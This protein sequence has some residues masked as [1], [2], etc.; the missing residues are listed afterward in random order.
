MPPAIDASHAPARKK[1]LI[2]ED[3][4]IVARD[5]KRRLEKQG[6]EVTGIADNAVD[7]LRSV[8]EN[9]PDIAL[10]DII[11]QGDRDGIATA[12]EMRTRHDMP[13]VFLTAHSDMAT[14]RRA[15]D[16][17]PY[18]YLVKPFEEREL[19]STIEVAVYRHQSE[20]Q[21]RL[22][23]RAISAT[24]VGMLITDACHP[25]HPIISCNA[26]FERI[27]GYTEAEIIGKNPRFLHGPDTDPEAVRVMR[28]AIRA[29]RN[30]QVTLCNCR[31]D[32]TA[33]WNEVSISPV[34]DAS[35][36]LTH[37]IGIQNDVTGRIQAAERIRQ[38]ARLIDQATDAIVV[39]DL[40]TRITFWNPAAE[41]LYGFTM[42]EV[43][44]LPVLD[45][46]FC[47]SPEKHEA[48][49]QEVRS[50]GEW[51]GEMPQRTQDGRRLIVLNRLTLLTDGRGTPAGVLSL[52][53][54][55]T[56]AKALE[57]Q[58]LR[59]QRQEALG[60]L[61]GGIAHDLNNALAPI[62]MGVDVLKA[63]YP[64]APAILDLFEASARRAA[65][66]V[67]QLLNF[68]KGT[69]GQHCRV[70]IGRLVREMQEII[71]GTFPK[72]ITISVDCDENLPQVMADPTQMHQVLLNLCVNARDAMPHGGTLTLDATHAEIGAMRA[73]QP[74]ASGAR[75]YVVL[76]VRDTGTGIPPEI[77]DHI[78][79]PFF[80]TKTMDKGTGLGLSTVMNIVKAHGGFLEVSSVP[81]QGTTFAACLPAAPPAGL[82]V[83]ETQV[84]IPFQG[85]G[86]TIL[87]VDDESAVREVAR[88]VLQRMNCKIVHAS[89]GVEALAVA[90]E[91][92]STLHAVITDMHMPNDDGVVFVT[93]LRQILPEIPVVVSSGRLEDDLKQQFQALGVTLFLD[94][95]F[96]ENQL[97]EALRS[98][99]SEG[100]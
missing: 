56:E 87:F 3:E 81:G 39:W 50:T 21:Q 35:G 83:P 69:E 34:R 26:A 8:E 71:E 28:D 2:V 42:Q 18:G 57:Q 66:M 7:A 72:N 95:P 77:I 84:Q 41:N 20:A 78:F 23:E 13:V 54:D 67:R 37:F 43:L 29:E 62:M 10:M 36:R 89:D 25:D 27:T 51:R 92:K 38:Q 100:G 4:G 94:K 63:S 22:Y 52:N 1:V 82:A 49:L 45:V 74:L 88:V 70:E 6:F 64:G 40:D 79:D 60:V 96:T 55:L 5:L 14:I 85:Q 80:S 24:T 31:K 46:I 93:A 65:S 91:H 44:G 53:H 32:G 86:E 58:F 90:N 97:A 73:G 33:F 12:H 98:L 9:P 47:E 59:A 30:C 68:A 99:F 15:K 19:L 75:P 16:A 76:T 61:A 11:I 17:L 48:I